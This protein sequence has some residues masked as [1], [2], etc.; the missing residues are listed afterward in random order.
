[1]SRAKVPDLRKYP[2]TAHAMKSHRIQ[3]TVNEVQ[4]TVHATCVTHPFGRSEMTAL[5]VN[6]VMT[7][8]SASAADQ[9]DDLTARELSKEAADFDLSLI[10]I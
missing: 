1:M 3:N 5:Q 8:P 4:E 7:G 2:G 10:H 9:G 6:P